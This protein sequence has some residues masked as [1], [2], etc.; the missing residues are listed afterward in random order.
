MSQSSTTTRTTPKIVYEGYAAEDIEENSIILKII[1]PE[2]TPHAVIGPVGAGITKGN[3]KLTD[4][5]GTAI[6]VPV[7]TANHIVASFDGNSN[8]RYP[9]MVRKGEQVEV[10]KVANQ[11]KYKWR[12]SGQ[13]RDF[14]KTDRIAFEI[15]AMPA[16]GKG[17]EKSDANTYSA[18]LD[19]VNQKAGFKTSKAN[20]EAA[21]FSVEFDLKAGSFTVS[22][23]TASPG[24]R[25]HLDSGVGTGNP[26]FQVNLSSG[27]TLKFENENAMITVPK[28]LLI[29]AGER[30]VFNSPLTIFNLSQVGAV[31][32]NAANIA[33]NGA[34]D[35]IVTGSVF[36]VNSTA[37]KF[38]GVLVAAAAR[39]TNIVK[40]SA[41][42][43]YTPTAINR[44]EESP[45]VPGSNSPDTNMSGAP[46]D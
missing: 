30:I 9:P 4:R 41:G 39:I 1:C 32:V 42:S 26:L 22:D 36:G 21:A 12:T 25:I 38:G 16:D 44:P 18:Y 37:S 3:T 15:G 28:K 29:N 13:G 33:L 45:V 35:V 40:G 31:I 2:L 23:D 43:N 11:D 14:R 7:T 20:G 5:D 27:L 34:K 8:Q 10:Y 19:S 6:T 46:Y 24:N 17:G